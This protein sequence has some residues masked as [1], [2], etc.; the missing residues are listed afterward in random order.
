MYWLFYLSLIH[1]YCFKIY[2]GEKDYGEIVGQD[3]EK[4]PVHIVNNLHDY[5]DDW[6]LSLIHISYWYGLEFSLKYGNK[7]L[8]VYYDQGGVDKYSYGCLLYTSRCV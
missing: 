5:D 2:E 7:Q 3:G 6:N 4:H 1:I 8:G